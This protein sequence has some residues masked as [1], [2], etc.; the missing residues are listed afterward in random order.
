M[1]PAPDCQSSG[2]VGHRFTEKHPKDCGINTNAT[3]GASFLLTLV[4]YDLKGLNA[5]VSR[6]VTIIS[7]CEDPDNF[8][9]DG[10]CSEVRAAHARACLL[11]SEG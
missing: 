3:I 8:I 2:C 11:C 4:V 5:S 6:L 7:P 10:V 1:C 9:C